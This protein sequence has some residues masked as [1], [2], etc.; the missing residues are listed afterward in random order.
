MEMTPA[1]SASVGAVQPSPMLGQHVLERL[2]HL[3]IVGMI[4]AGTHLVEHQLSSMFDVSRGPIRDALRQLETEGLVESRRR[5]VFATGLTENDILELYSLRQL[6]EANAVQN[7]MA[8]DLGLNGFE[9]IVDEMGAAARERDAIAF[10]MADLEFHSTFHRGLDNRRLESI[11]DQY[12][13]TFVDMV[14]LTNGEDSDLASTHRDH[15]ALL[16]LIESGDVAQALSLLREHIDGSQRRMVAA[17]S[18]HHTRAAT[19]D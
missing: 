8:R 5:G 1:W 4:P 6:L 19:N 13:P 18:R 2:R 9:H 7:W 15:I 12:R 14:T 11:W 3:I 17:H 16:K 10:A